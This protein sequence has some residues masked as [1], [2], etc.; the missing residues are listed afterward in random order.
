MSSVN[1]P[2][3]V[4]YCAELNSSLGGHT[5]TVSSQ[6]TT[7]WKYSVDWTVGVSG[8]A[9]ARTLD[10]TTLTNGPLCLQTLN[11]CKYSA[12]SV[13]Y[14]RH[15]LRREKWPFRKEPI[16]GKVVHGNEITCAPTSHSDQILLK[17]ISIFYSPSILLYN[18]IALDSWQDIVRDWRFIWFVRGKHLRIRERVKKLTSVSTPLSSIHSIHPVIKYP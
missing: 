13:K 2:Q 18:W 8:G 6:L 15:N 12:Q 5:F 16:K 14:T 9:A 3:F 7:L 10:L 17:T 1:W 4:E 11:L